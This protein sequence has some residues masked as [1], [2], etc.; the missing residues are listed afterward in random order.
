LKSSLKGSSEE[1]TFKQIDDVYNV[2]DKI[3]DV[4]KESLYPKEE[5]HSYESIHNGIRSVK[6]SNDD[7]TMSHR[8]I[9]LVFSDYVMRDL[10]L[11]SVL[12]NRKGMAIVFLAYMKYRICSALIATKILKKYSDNAQ[13]KDMKEK[14]GEDAT[15]FENYAIDCIKQCHAKDTDLACEIVL[16]Q[17]ELY[18]QVTCLQVRSSFFILYAIILYA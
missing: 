18:G 1:P 12:M 6:S 17:I 2:I 11:W 15:F 16:Q 3:I 8:K 10:F 14:Y 9:N 13:N 7:V 5:D 4:P